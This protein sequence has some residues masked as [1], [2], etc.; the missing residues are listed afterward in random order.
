MNLY[1]YIGF[2]KDYWSGPLLERRLYFSNLNQVRD[3]NDKRELDHEW[4]SESYF[5]SQY[6]QLLQDSYAR[7][8]NPARLLCLGKAL[9]RKCWAR[10][11][12][13]PDGGVCYEFSFSEQKKAKDLTSG[14]VEYAKTKN[15]NVPSFIIKNV[16]NQR[17][18][19][20]LLRTVRPA[21][22]EMRELLIWLDTTEPRAITQQ[23]IVKEL[24]FKKMIEYRVENEYRFIHPEKSGGK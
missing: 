14:H 22:T 19:D 20:L 11:C 4:Q 17:I 24:V 5:F 7:L 10:F 1:K 21:N 3:I 9:N 13:T 6:G 12:S 23:H 15:H 16:T 8:F 2:D 18:R